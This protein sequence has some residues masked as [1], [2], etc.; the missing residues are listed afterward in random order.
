MSLIPPTNNFIFKPLLA[1]NEALVLDILNSFP[2]FE[3]DR[4]ILSIKILNPELPKTSDR[5]KVILLDYPSL[6][7]NFFERKFVPKHG[8]F[9]YNLS[10]FG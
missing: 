5:E 2:E 1:K 10:P 7:H 3:G 8:G 6:F 9:P 4:K